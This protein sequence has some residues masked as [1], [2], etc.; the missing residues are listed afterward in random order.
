M[1]NPASVRIRGPLK[2][3]LAGFWSVLRKQRYSPSH[4][5]HLLRL[6]ADL[7][8]WLEDHALAPGELDTAR[9]VQFAAHRQRRRY[10]MFCTPL[11][12]RPLLGYLRDIGI[13]PPSPAPAETTLDRLL[14]EYGEYLARE[15]GLVASTIRGYTDFARHFT[16][17]QF[18][19]QRLDFRRLGAAD[20]TSFLL[21]EFRCSGIAKCKMAVS[22][23]RSLLRYLHLRGRLAHDLSGCVPAVAGWRLARLPKTLEPEQVKRVLASCKR[24]TPVGCRDRAV[25]CLLARL[26]LRAGEVAALCLADIDWRAGEV[27]IHG[28]GCRESRLPLPADVGRA[29]TAYLRRRPRTDIRSVFLCVHAPLRPI[30]SAAISGLARHAL[31]ATGVTAGSAHLL[32]HTAATQMLR[33]GASLAEVGHVLRHRHADTTAIYAKVDHAGLRTLAQPWPGG[34]A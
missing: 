2:S 19:S 6:A 28:K 4:L 23:L 8:R 5:G 7:S 16:S 32:R 1:V 33:H 12:L 9:I 22:G 21:R 29:L 26:G 14:R 30:S 3:Y 31:R 17:V 18:D 34:A 20:V 15:R 27:V 11:A 13:V 24:S 10:S 25:L